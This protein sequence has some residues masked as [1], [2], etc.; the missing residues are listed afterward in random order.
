MPV[1]WVLPPGVRGLQG[2]VGS[3]ESYLGGYLSGDLELG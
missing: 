3:W 1:G 2:L